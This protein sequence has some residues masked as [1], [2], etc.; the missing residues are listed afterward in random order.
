MMLSQT[1][2]SPT[3]PP[4]PLHQPNSDASVCGAI[5]SHSSRVDYDFRLNIRSLFF[6]SLPSTFEEMMLSAT[7]A[8]AA[9]VVVTIIGF[10]I[11]DIRNEKENDLQLV[12][13]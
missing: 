9:V 4:P 2:P 3:P 10:P 11:D 5:V 6:P 13:G 7:A 1:S 8:G 12:K